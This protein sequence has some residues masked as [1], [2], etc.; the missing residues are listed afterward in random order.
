MYDLITI[1]DIKMDTFVVLKEASIQCELKMPECLL[2]LEYGAKIDVDVVDSQIAGTAPNVATALARMGKK[3]AV[4]SVMGEDGTHIL[5]KQVLT[6]EGVSHSHIHVVNDERSSFAVVLNYKGEKTI[7]TSHISHKYHFPEPFPACK[8]V[9]VGEMGGGYE[10]LY[11]ALLHHEDGGG[12]KIGFN[13]G[14]VQIK[15][16]K[17]VLFDLIKRC[18]ILFVNTDEARELTNQHTS[19]IRRLATKV[20][21]LGPRIAILTDGSR[22][23]YAFDGTTL[24]F[25]PVFPAKLVE[26]TGSG[27]AFASGV[28]GALMQKHPLK[29]ALAWGSVNAASVIGFV[30]P[31]R[32][33]LSV[34]EIEKRLRKEKGYKVQIV[35]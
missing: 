10:G 14:S 31:T 25:S 21:E 13:P 28:L 24:F 27:D 20:Y 32:G 6:K 33:L 1:G 30:G 17:K 7:L 26:A 11:A 19:E 8:W 22:G 15:E 23:A 12:Y 3:T 34:D 4:V 2:C 16:R 35:A 18:D 9:Y 29:D 5:A